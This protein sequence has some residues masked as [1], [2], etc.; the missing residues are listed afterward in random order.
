MTVSARVILQLAPWNHKDWK[1]VQPRSGNE[2]RSECCRMD[3]HDTIYY[4]SDATQ[5]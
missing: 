1:E 2:E 4:F 3:E 5:S